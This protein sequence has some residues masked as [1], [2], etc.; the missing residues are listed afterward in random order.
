MK[1]TTH[2][3]LA[4]TLWGDDSWL[5]FGFLT[6]SGSLL[7]WLSAKLQIPFYPVPMTMQMLLVLLI[8]GIFGYKLGVST[9]SLYLIQGAVGLPVF[10]GTPEKG[11]GMVYMLGPTGGYLVGFLIAAA[12]V[13]WLA[14][15]GGARTL[16]STA[17]IMFLGTAA[18]Y[19]PGLLWLG[20]VI[21][22]DKP[23]L[24]FGLYPFV[25]GDLLK[26]LIAT[27]TMPML[28]KFVNNKKP[29]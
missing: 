10:A 1:I 28:W 7:L 23:I 6:L 29:S 21:G 22:W 4:S 25:Y 20:A 12:L 14:E 19:I 18:I 15:R 8:A 16:L 2:S 26:I 9:V 27:L 11:I 3:T 13:G 24:Q 17:L 5:R